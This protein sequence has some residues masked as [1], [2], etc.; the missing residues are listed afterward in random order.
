[1]TAQLVLGNG[2]GVALA[3]DSAVT[4]SGAQQ[5]RTFDT[6]E[7]IHPLTDPHR[8]GVLHCGAVHY[9]G[10]PVGVLLDEWKAS[11]GSRLQS[12]EGYRDNFLSWLADNLDNWSTSVDRE[13]NSFESLDRRLWQVARSVKEEVE[14]VAEDLRHDTALTVVR[15][16][17][18]MLES[19]EPNDPQLKDMAD[20][21]LARWGADGVEGVPSLGPR[22][23]HWFDDLPRSAEIDQEV[24]RFIRLTV[25]GG[26]EFPSAATTTISFVGYGLKEMFPSL[27]SVS[28]FGAIGS[29]VAHHKLMPLFAEPHGPS[30]ALIV[31]QAQSDVMEQVLTGINTPLIARS[32]E[33]TMERLREPTDQLTEPSDGEETLSDAAQVFTENVRN[34]LMSDLKQRS[35]EEHLDPALR[36]IAG[37]PLASLA[38]I[39][40]AL[41]AIQNLTLDIRGELPTVGGNIDIATITLSEGFKWVNHKGRTR[42]PFL[43]DVQ[44]D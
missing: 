43:P 39:A 15:E 11:L 32:A 34:E 4:S 25:E 8:L 10:M 18:E 31:P 33:T 16:T 27:A 37:M 38:E 28:L 20:D 44:I 30:Y 35:Q 12:V 19:W 14:S 13:W 42:Q 22:I 3:S 6:S 36:T 41:V 9:L 21:I 5:S 40:G 2:F 17:N 29:H 1:M 7:K 26:Y 24:H 23:E